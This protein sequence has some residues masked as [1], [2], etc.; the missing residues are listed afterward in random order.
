VLSEC[1]CNSMIN[2]NIKLKQFFCETLGTATTKTHP[3]RKRN[4]LNAFDVN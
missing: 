1:F 3:L 4:I 2:V